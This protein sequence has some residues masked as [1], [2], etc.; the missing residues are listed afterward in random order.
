MKKKIVLLWLLC[1]R[2]C[3]AQPQ[4]DFLQA[5]YAYH[6][7]DYKKAFEL[8]QHIAGKGRAAW[9]NMGN[10]AYHMKNYVEA[11][12]YWSRA[13]RQSTRQEYKDIQE[14]KAHVYTAL[15]MQ[16]PIE[17]QHMLL[18]VVSMVPWFLLQ[19]ILLVTCF[20]LYG[21]CYKKRFFILLIMLYSVLFSGAYVCYTYYKTQQALYAYTVKKT[22]SVRSGPDNRSHERSQLQYATKV[23]VQEQRTDWSKISYDKQHGWVETASLIGI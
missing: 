9:Y 19:I 10:C 4:E 17:D 2:F 12:V 14:N 8:Y 3:Y 7:G 1:I 22:V 21:F 16:Q 15:H 11:L 6:A 13:E 23:R 5:N 20:L 18:A